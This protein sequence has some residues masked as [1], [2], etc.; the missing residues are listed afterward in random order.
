MYKVQCATEEK[1]RDQE[2][3]QTTEFVTAPRETAAAATVAKTKS[4]P[5]AATKQRQKK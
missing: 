3:Q 2:S 5:E 4:I 1:H